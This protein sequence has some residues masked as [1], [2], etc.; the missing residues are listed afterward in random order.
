LVLIFSGGVL[1]AALLRI[2]LSDTS[3]GLLHIRSRTF[4]TLL[5]LGVGAAILLLG[6]IVTN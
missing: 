6:L 5:L 3:A 1:L 2:G 4:D